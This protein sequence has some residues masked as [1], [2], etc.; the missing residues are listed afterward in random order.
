[1]LTNESYFKSGFTDGYKGRAFEPPTEN[2]SRAYY[3]AGFNVAR[4]ENIFKCAT[5]SDKKII[6]LSLEGLT[7][8]QTNL[9]IN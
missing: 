5:E 1:M 2:Y 6:T 4:D 7:E 8:L 9:Y 3:L